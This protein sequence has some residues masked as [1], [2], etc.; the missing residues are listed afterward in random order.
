MNMDF[1]HKI[2]IQIY[3][4]FIEAWLSTKQLKRI[5]IE[6]MV[7]RAYNLEIEVENIDSASFMQSSSVWI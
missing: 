2:D 5:K 3:V 7:L 4:E 6:L 1:W